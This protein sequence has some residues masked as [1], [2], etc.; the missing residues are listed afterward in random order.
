MICRVSPA[1]PRLPEFAADF[2][3]GVRIGPLRL[4]DAPAVHAAVADPVLRRWLPLPRPYPL[5]LAEQW[6]TT[7]SQEI[8]DSGRGLVRGVFADDR[9]VGCIDAKRIDW[10]ARVAEIGYWTA[11]PARGRGHMTAAVVALAGWLLREQ[12]FERVELRIAPGNAASRR[13]AE[14]ARFV[15]EGTARNAGF[16]DGGRVDLQIFSRVPGDPD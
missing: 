7:L 10:A 4:A 14:K 3:P 9:L 2:A 11:A 6:C 12:A 5:E 16:T 13:V 1:P 8:R 15:Y